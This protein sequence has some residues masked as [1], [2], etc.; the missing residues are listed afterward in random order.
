M[1]TE[2]Y[3]LIIIGAGLCGLTIGKAL[4]SSSINFKI[5][6]KSKAFGGRAATRRVFGQAIDHGAQYFTISDER[7]LAWVEDL[8][9]EDLVRPWVNQLHIWNGQK[10]FLEENY[11]T[12]YICPL[13]MTIM[14]KELA[15]VLPVSREVKILKANKGDITKKQNYGWHL[16][17]DGLLEIFA[18]RIV[19]TAPLQQSLDLFANYLD[20][21][22]KERL[23]LIEYEPCLC[24]IFT[25]P[26]NYK[27]NW[28]GI[29]WNAGEIIS[30]V[31][32]DSSKR[33]EPLQTVLVIHCKPE[34]SKKYF[35][36]PEE[37]VLNLILQ[38]LEMAFPSWIE[39]TQGKQLKKW[40]YAQPTSLLGRP[41]FVAA[42]ETLF[43]TGDWCLNPRLEGAFITALEVAKALQ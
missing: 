17:T 24:A 28:K 36:A 1:L 35:E 11:T 33:D 19:C 2:R 3:D 14:A 6:E 22:Q 29:F 7:F 20:E 23:K 31:A 15:H 8:E 12:R 13:G 43:L 27:P 38:E 32:H 9:E 10:F 40:R 4:T 37:Q 25:Y 21:K 30:W 18:D 26:L 39:E 41:Y 42:E 5:F 34:F 16:L